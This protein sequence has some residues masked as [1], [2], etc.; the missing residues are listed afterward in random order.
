MKTKPEL[1]LAD[2]K[3]QLSRDRF[4]GFKTAGQLDSPPMA[5]AKLLRYLDRADFGSNPV[6]DVRDA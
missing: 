2:V 4:L 5:A 6:G 1:E 3:A